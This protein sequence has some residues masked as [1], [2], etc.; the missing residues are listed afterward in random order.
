MP[1]M[2]DIK[3]RIRSVS[4]TKKTT[5]AMNLVSSSKLQ[6]AKIKLNRGGPFF[7]EIR[8]VVGN[9]IKNTDEV[10]PYFEKRPVKKTLIIT[11]AN[12]RGLC[13]GYNVNICKHTFNLAK[14]IEN[15][16]VF[17]TIGNKSRDYFRRLGETSINHISGI[18]E[19]PFYEDG[20]KIAK[21]IIEL[22]ENHEID[23]V[24]IA[25][26]EFISAINYVPSHMKLLPLSSE[27]FVVENDSQ[28][29][30]VMGFEPNPIEVLNHI[31][32]KYITVMIY[33]SLAE[34]AASG[35]GATM[36]AM[37]SATENASNIIDNLT[38]MYNRARQG[39]I[40]QEI[41]EIVAGANA[42]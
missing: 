40:T 26:T 11:I 15:E 19:N 1:T 6:R 37:D 9:I 32:P 23:E 38:L 30:Q 18:S 42:I 22:Y 8:Q 31:L 2:R 21:E 12:D 20:E 27:D 35:Q 39:A 5:K 3:G 24:Y 13:G 4:T 7:K 29:I 10:H 17:Y 33:A 16:K 36:T 41:S 14:S 25:Y 34:S 28:Y